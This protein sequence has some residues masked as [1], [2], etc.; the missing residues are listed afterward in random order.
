MKSRHRR[1][2]RDAE[3]SAGATAIGEMRSVCEG[4]SSALRFAS[5]L[6]VGSI[7]PTSM[8][9]GSRRIG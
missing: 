2:S 1:V 9:T 6:T 3:R 8:A 5:R 4:I 7:D